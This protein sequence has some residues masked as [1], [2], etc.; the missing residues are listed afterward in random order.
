V[1]HFFRGVNTMR[2]AV[3]ISGLLLFAASTLFA[4]EN[5]TDFE[6]NWPQFRGSDSNQLSKSA[7]LPEEWD[8]NKNV[9]W[10]FE[11]PGSGWS[12][13]IVW[14]DK[15]FVNTAVSDDL[16]TEQ[17]SY[18][19]TPSTKRSSADDYDP[20]TEY[21]YELHCLDLNSGELLWKRVAYK[22]KPYLA[23]RW[24]NTHS[25]ETP[26]T[27]GK[28]IYAYFGMI[29]LFC[30]DFDG[31]LVWNKDLGSYPTES[32][33][34]AASSPILYEDFLYV[35]IDNLEHSFLV[36]LDSE[37]GNEKWKI[38]RDDNNSFSTPVIW[39]NSVRTEL[40]VSGQSARGYDPYTGK[41]FWELDLGG[42]RNIPSPVADDKFLY[43]GNQGRRDGG[44]IL[45]AVKAGANGNI[46]PEEE[47]ST[48]AGV[49][50]SIPSAGLSN[51]SPLLYKGNIYLVNERSGFI[52]CYDAKSGKPYYQRTRIPDAEAFWATP[53]A[54]NDKIFCLDDAG[55]TFVLEAGNEFNILYENK[56]DDMFWPSAALVEDTIVLR[57]VNY[58]YCIRQTD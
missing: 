35:Q 9:L 27:D 42:G 39:K 25:N 40:V 23:T 15:V 43:A 58:I 6:N 31:N 24:E 8:E 21:S 29:G 20:E 16:T 5:P 49:A 54:F 38:D 57:G 3:I 14:G 46:T 48:S 50:W 36:A 51:S 2:S 41:M 30:Y 11:L 19:H 32:T 45:F 44:D 18:L 26:V 52:S 7:S 1:T 55:T 10:K 47:N 12:S 28:R 33:W 53:W 56:I 37:T 4:Q 13:P 34:G 22:G 17:R